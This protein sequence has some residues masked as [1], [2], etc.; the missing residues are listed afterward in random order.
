MTKGEFIKSIFKPAIEW[1]AKKIWPWLASVITALAIFFLSV[2]NKLIEHPNVLL[3]LLTIMTAT[4]VLFLILWIRIYWQ[5]E[6]FQL[7]FGVSWDKNYNMRCSSCKKPLKESTTST[8]LFYC[9][10]PKCDSRYPLKDDIG[11]EITKRMAII[12]LMQTA[13]HKKRKK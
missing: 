11:T 2:K 9:S 10:D 8:S 3:V 4:T 5:Y 13:K 6:R 12:S 1:V 7:V